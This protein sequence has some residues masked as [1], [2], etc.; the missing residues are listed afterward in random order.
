MMEL[1]H[2]DCL[3]EMKRIAD[4]SIDLILSDPPYGTTGNAWDE[5]IPFDALWAH[6][7]R[8]IRP[9]GPVVVFGSE[10]F[11]TTLRMSNRPWFKYD[12]IW[13]KSR[14]G[15]IFGAKLRPMKI[16]EVISVFSEGTTAAGSDKLMPYYPQGVGAGGRAAS[17][18]TYA[19]AA[20]K[21]ERPSLTDNPVHM[22]D[23]SNYPRSIL[24]FGN[25]FT[26][27]LHPTQKPV[28]IM[29][30]LIQTYTKPGETVL[31]PTMGSGTTG[32]ACRRLG[33]KF[34]GIEKDPKYFEIAKER[35]EAAQAQMD[36]LVDQ[37]EPEQES[38]L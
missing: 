23:G 12:W 27:R 32:V 17:N 36:F 14:P 37:T 33:R 6:L 7:K 16:H 28:E 22:T 30:Y 35:I 15:G 1:I 25:V 20:F 38:F 19:D 34:I 24:R 2:G 8:L 11:S 5:V 3:T 13:E 4:G 10:P 29:E 21:G 31:D 26:E 9:L 18:V